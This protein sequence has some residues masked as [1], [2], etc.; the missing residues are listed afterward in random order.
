M[1][2]MVIKGELKM[3][4][5]GDLVKRPTVAFTLDEH[6]ALKLYCVQNDISIQDYIRKSVLHC[7][8]NE[9]QVEMR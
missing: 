6:K 4:E 3:Y 7:L 1:K 9:V 8:S 2:E 5:K